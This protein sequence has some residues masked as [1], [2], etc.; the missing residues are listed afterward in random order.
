MRSAPHPLPAAAWGILLDGYVHAG[1]LKVLTPL[2]PSPSCPPP[3]AVG[4][5]QLLRGHHQKT[6]VHISFLIAVVRWDEIS[7][8]RIGLSGK[9]CVPK[10]TSLA[11]K[12]KR[13]WAAWGASCMFFSV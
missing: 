10:M 2:L 13:R 12:C 1:Q 3:C 5:Q 11:A 6:A 7:S 8:G 4:L 9:G